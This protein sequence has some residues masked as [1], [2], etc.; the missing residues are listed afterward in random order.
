MLKTR[1][2]DEHGKLMVGD[3]PGRVLIICDGCGKRAEVFY[4]HMRNGKLTD[5]CG[6]CHFAAK[7]SRVQ[8][9]AVTA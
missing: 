4:W 8:G 9:K 5:L 1:K 7:M 2:Y 6:T 3:Q